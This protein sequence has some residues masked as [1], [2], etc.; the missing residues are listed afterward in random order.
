MQWAALMHISVPVFYDLRHNSFLVYGILRRQLGRS[1]PA[2]NKNIFVYNT[3]QI[4]NGNHAT[5]IQCF[6]P[7]H[8]AQIQRL[9]YEYVNNILFL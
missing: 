9:L 4:Q 8:T 3:K 1:W 5:S 6:Y 7:N 2:Q